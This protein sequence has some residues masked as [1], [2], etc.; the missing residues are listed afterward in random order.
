MGDGRFKKGDTPWNKGRKMSPELYDKCK[1]T[2][3]KKGNVPGNIK[4]YGK[5]YL[6]TR[7]RNNQTERTWFIRVNNKR[8]HFLKYLCEIN[9]INLRGKIPRL[10]EGFDINKE[11]TIDDIIIITKKENMHLNSYQRFPKNLRR[12]I[13]IKGA[14]TRQINKNSYEI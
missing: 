10:K 8:L 13:Q 3:F 1:E 4:H 14:L 6:L 2:M 5:P 9:D 7:E 12:L 11:P